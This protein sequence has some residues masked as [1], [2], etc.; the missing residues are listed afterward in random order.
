MTVRIALELPSFDTGEYEGFEYLMSEGGSVLTVKL[1]KSPSVAIAFKRTRWH[2]FTQLHNCEARWINEAYFR[3]VEVDAA[4]SLDAYVQADTSS[5]QPY[6]E[7]R[8]YRIFLDESGC[9]EVFAE[10]A[11]FL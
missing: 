4:E 11:Q 1:S 6:N 3:L 8:H 7:L 5:K 10:S 2:R 9:H